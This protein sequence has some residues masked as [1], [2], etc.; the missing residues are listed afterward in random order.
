M[1]PGLTLLSFMNRQLLPWPHCC[2]ATPQEKVL[3]KCEVPD[4]VKG[5]LGRLKELF[6]KPQYPNYYNTSV[7]TADFLEVLS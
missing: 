2:A 3:A 5:V 6:F 7:A 4:H 1:C